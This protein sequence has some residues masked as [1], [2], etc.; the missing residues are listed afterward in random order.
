MIKSDL[1]TNAQRPNPKTKQLEW[2]EVDLTD[3][4]D[5]EFCNMW[6]SITDDKEKF[7]IANTLRQCCI[8]LSDFGDQ[9]QP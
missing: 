8:G 1:V 2:V 4:S 5:E 9:G 7:T 6:L 3:L